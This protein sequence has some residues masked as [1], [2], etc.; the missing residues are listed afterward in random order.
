[1]DFLISTYT[2][3]SLKVYV[4]I[5]IFSY[6]LIKVRIDKTM[7]PF[8]NFNPKHLAAALL[9]TLLAPF[10]LLIFYL[11]IILFILLT[12]GHVGYFF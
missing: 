7:Q 5:Y 6:I 3:F 8:Q 12:G 1:M 10:A 4:L 2:M 9:I 11:P